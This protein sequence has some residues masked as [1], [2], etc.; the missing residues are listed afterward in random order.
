MLPHGTVTARGATSASSSTQLCGAKG[1]GSGLVTSSP[2]NSKRLQQ[3]R[4]RC[5]HLAPVF[6]EMF[7]PTPT[8]LHTEHLRSW[9]TASG[10]VEVPVPKFGT[11]RPPMFCFIA[12]NLAQ[13]WHVL[14]N[15]DATANPFAAAREC[16]PTA[17]MQQSSSL[18]MLAAA[19]VTMRRARWRTTLGLW[20]RL[21]KEAWWRASQWLPCQFSAG[22]QRFTVD[23]A[24]L[25]QPT[26]SASSRRG[27]ALGSPR[28]QQR[29]QHKAGH[30]RPAMRRLRACALCR[31]L[32]RAVCSRWGQLSV[33]CARGA[34]P[35]YR[36]LSCRCATDGRPAVCSSTTLCRHHLQWHASLLQCHAV[37]EQL[38]ELTTRPPESPLSAAQTEHICVGLTAP[39][40]VSTQSCTHVL[41]GVLDVQPN[42]RRTTDGW[43]ETAAAACRGHKV[44][45]AGRNP[46]RGSGNS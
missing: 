27:P 45:H 18:A 2:R 12:T 31:W 24:A 5:R 38:D 3:P 42:G 11:E 39:Q 25:C 6:S 32:T 4:E 34:C 22:S 20:V 1:A 19:S 17:S 43:P 29:L 14:Q 15:H 9:I 41:V 28:R 30:I 44:A 36:L 13:L 21:A 33:M 7:Q 37:C 16:R 46:G 26:K 8:G 35:G 40:A 10:H 23:A